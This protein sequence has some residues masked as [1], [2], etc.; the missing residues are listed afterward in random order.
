MRTGFRPPRPF[1]PLLA[2]LA[3]LAAPLSAS[4]V[5][6]SS[7]LPSGRPAPADSALREQTFRHGRFGQV[8]LYRAGDRP[9]RVVLFVSGDGGWN[10]GV[11]GMARHL[12]ERGAL[13]AGIDIRAY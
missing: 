1:P 4:I 10:L 11:V 6:A 9:A 5:L 13:V 12:A 2:A 3:L 8:S 7:S